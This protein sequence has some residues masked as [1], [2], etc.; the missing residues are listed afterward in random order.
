LRFVDDL[1]RTVNG[2]VQRFRLRELAV[3][4]V[5]DLLES[6]APDYLSTPL[7]AHA[8][9]DHRELVMSLDT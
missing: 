4:T 2:K 5:P 7:P 1:P 3:A 9:E 6:P 8:K